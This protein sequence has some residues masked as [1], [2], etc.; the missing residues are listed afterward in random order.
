MTG[1]SGAQTP[2]V[3]ALAHRVANAKQRP[4]A[5]HGK[6][7]NTTVYEQNYFL[8]KLPKKKEDKILTDCFHSIFTKS[9][10]S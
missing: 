7:V 1:R 6:G 9:V 5:L 2:A 3:I 4:E 8:L 10:Q